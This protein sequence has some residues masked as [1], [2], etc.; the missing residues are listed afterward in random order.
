MTSA[1]S[2]NL[3][4]MFVRTVWPSREAKVSLPPLQF[5]VF[6]RQDVIWNMTSQTELTGMAVSPSGL[7]ISWLQQRTF[8]W[9]M[10]RSTRPLWHSCRGAIQCT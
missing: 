4:A 2:A 8:R 5:R 7:G 9:R 3:S 6:L 1:L 10:V